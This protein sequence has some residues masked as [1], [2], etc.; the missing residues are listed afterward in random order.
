[1]E[2]IEV[3][4]QA[5]SRAIANP[6]EVPPA[7]RA[8]RMEASYRQALASRGRVI[9]A[10]GFETFVT[11]PVGMLVKVRCCVAH[12]RDGV[13]WEA[14]G[15]FDHMLQ[16]LDASGDPA[17][18][19]PTR[20][21]LRRRYERL[22]RI[23]A[24]VVREKRLRPAHALGEDTARGAI[25][26]GIEIHLGPGGEPIFGDAGT[27]RLAMARVIGLRR[28]PALLGVVHESAVSHLPRLRRIGAST[29]TMISHWG[30]ALVAI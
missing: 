10:A 8:E 23:F 14:T 5:I 11:V 21:D 30:M 7:A 15:I 13:S 12:W 1:M 18:D 29:I 17:G 22:D 20:A 24:Q 27:H 25:W 4:V 26:N 3:P 19:R 16:K 9:D 6:L 28:V 2:P